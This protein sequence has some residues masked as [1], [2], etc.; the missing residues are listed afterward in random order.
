MNVIIAAAVLLT[1]GLLGYIFLIPDRLASAREQTRLDYLRERKDV[2]YENLRDLSFEFK[3]GKLPEPDYVSTRNALEDEA[4]A[5]LV[6]IEDLE[7]RQPE[8]ATV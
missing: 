6:E 4:V 1:L 7:K 3:A 8:G 2:V 5:L